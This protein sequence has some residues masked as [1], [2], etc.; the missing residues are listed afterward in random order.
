[1]PKPYWLEAFSTTAYLI[2]RLP[3]PILNSTSPYKVLFNTHPD[4]SHLRTFGCAC[5]PYLGP[6]K[7]DKLSPKSILCVFLGYSTHSKGYRCLD[8]KTNKIYT[9]R[10]VVFDESTFPFT[11]MVSTSPTL[12]THHQWVNLPILSQKLLSGPVSSPSSSL[13]PSP[14][15]SISPPS[16]SLP[17]PNS[18]PPTVQSEPMLNTPQS[19]TPP[20]HSIP[21][22]PPPSSLPTTS[23]SP[24]PPSPPPYRLVPS[25]PMVTRLKS[26]LTRLKPITLL[27]PLRIT[28]SSAD[29]DNDSAKP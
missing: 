15:P 6:Y 14:Q 29:D 2:N 4:Y 26:D 23:V 13:S 8:P 18:S 5:Y 3:T 19:V 7:H 24:N 11:S 9:S 20:N 12:A 25:H 17:Q 1:M 21:D 10:H 16:I 27:L 28:S 22:T